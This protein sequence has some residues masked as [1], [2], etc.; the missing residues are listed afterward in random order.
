MPQCGCAGLTSRR[1]FSQLQRHLTLQS[2]QREKDQN[3]IDSGS[4]RSLLTLMSPFSS[5]SNALTKVLNCS[6][7]GFRLVFSQSWMLDLGSPAPSSSVHASISPRRFCTVGTVVGSNSSSLPGRVSMGTQTLPVPGCTTNGDLSKWFSF[8]LTSIS[9]LGYVYSSTISCF[10]ARRS[11][12]SRF[13]L[14]P[15]ALVMASMSAHFDVEDRPGAEAHFFRKE[16]FSV[17]SGNSCRSFSARSSVSQ[18]SCFSR[19]SSAKCGARMSRLRLR[20]MSVHLAASHVARNRT[21][22]K[23]GCNG[24]LTF[25]FLPL[26][27]PPL[28]TS[29]Y[30][31]TALLFWS[32]IVRAFLSQTQAWA[33]RRPE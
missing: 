32:S 18:G 28:R 11:F 25:T 15:P 10:A 5:F 30:P 1:V 22:V 6:I 12:V 31:A 33:P 16:S 4:S 8:L 19:T 20:S 3:S 27:A 26:C 7:Y 17:L 14:A 23:C 21:H 9:S 24:L 29:K 2:H 13:L